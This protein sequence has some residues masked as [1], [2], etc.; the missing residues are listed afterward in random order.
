MASI[1]VS[2]GLQ[3]IGVQSSQATGTGVTYSATRHI[4]VMSVDDGT[5]AFAA[6]HT[7]LNSGGA[8]TNEYDQAFDST[9]TRTNQTITH[10]MTIG[11]GN[12][13]F[14]IKRIAMHDNVVGSVDATTATLVCGVDGQTLGKT[15]DFTLAITLNLLY[16][17]V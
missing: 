7:A 9:P 3:R 14:T 16:T 1:V 4:Q 8:I 11:T 15:S 2:N 13:N 10:I 6:G 5:V 17:S 12:G